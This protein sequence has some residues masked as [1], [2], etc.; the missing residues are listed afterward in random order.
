MK[1]LLLLVAISVA[2]ITTH[3]QVTEFHIYPNGLIYSDAT[4][5]RLKFIVDS[6]QLKFKSCDLSKDYYSI[7]Q[8]KGHYI[9]LDT[10]NIK[11]A[12]AD[13]REDMDYYGFLKKYPLA[14]VDSFVLIT[15][16]DDENYEHR[17][18][19][20]YTNQSGHDHSKSSVHIFK[21]PDWKADSSGRHI[22]GKMGKWVFDCTCPDQYSE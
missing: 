7:R 5:D 8:Q 14:E 22:F 19:L 2:G 4:M 6:L 11:A 15:E 10:G 16:S 9:R 12:L 1:Q 17:K 21:N 3:S 18:M 13:M 20:A